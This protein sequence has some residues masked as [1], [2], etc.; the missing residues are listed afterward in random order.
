MCLA[1]FHRQLRS[2]TFNA[3]ATDKPIPSTTIATPWYC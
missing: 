1:M 2:N 3:D